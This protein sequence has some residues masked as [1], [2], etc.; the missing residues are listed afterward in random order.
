MQNINQ[1]KERQG[2]IHAIIQVFILCKNLSYI[3]FFINYKNWKIN[4]HVGSM[5]LK[6]SL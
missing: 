4:E 1:K 3:L 6:K 5:D 2:S